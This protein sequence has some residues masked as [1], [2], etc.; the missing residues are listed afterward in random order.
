MSSRLSKTAIDFVQY[1]AELISLLRDPECIIFFDTNILS[2]MY[3]LFGDARKEVYFWIS[4]NKSRI[5]VTSWTYSEYMK[6]AINNTKLQEF[7]PIRLS[8]LVKEY[9]EQKNHLNYFGSSRSRVG[10]NA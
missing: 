7:Y 9:S 2:Q 10:K 4:T 5:K 1:R 6:R 3:K 8:T